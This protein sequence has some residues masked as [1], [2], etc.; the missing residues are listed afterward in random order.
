MIWKGGFFMR[1]SRVPMVFLALF[2]ALFMENLD[3]TVMATIAPSVAADLHGM[4]IF[5]WVFS[6]Y[7]LASTIFIPIFGKLAD[8]FGKKPFLLGGLAVFTVASFLSANAE[9][10]EQ[11]VAY[12]AM[13]GLG[14]APMM[15]IAFSMIYELSRPERR[16]AMQGLFGSVSGLSML[17]GPAIGAYL[18]D[19]FTWHWVFLMNIPLGLAAFLLILFFYGENRSRQR[20]A[21][22]YRGA[23]ALVAAVAPLM[24]GLALG[25]ETYPWLSAPIAGLFA[26]SAAFLFLFVLIERKAVE[27][28]VDFRLFNRR[29]AASSA[30]VFLQGVAAVSVMI[31]LPLY[32]Q[33][34]RGGSATQ[35]G[36]T[37][38]FLIVAVM[39]G[40]IAGGH[41]LAK[42]SPRSVLTAASAL[43][44]ISAWM[45]TLIDTQS[46]T[47][48]FVSALV[49]MGLGIGPLFPVTML[50]AQTSV[51]P[52][53][54]TS[55]TSLLNFLR[56]IGMAIGSSGLAVL[57]NR[58]VAESSERAAS[59]ALTPEQ[60]ELLRDPNV[61]IDTGMHTFVPAEALL[62]LRE[63]LNAGIAQVF[64]ATFAAVVLI[65]AFS[66]L[67]GKGK[68]EMK[69]ELKHVRYH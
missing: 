57:V 46:S 27:P 65:A 9:T 28:I 24:L 51:K 5:S 32:I 40:T 44:G 68:L 59:G 12:R 35:V 19:H 39:V 7:L 45:L 50:V 11:L 23:A 33:G 29:V 6:V 20:S 30:I 66:L 36:T 69:E 21:I 8:Q 2:I 58:R 4:H 26:A 25:G 47:Y 17:A 31:Y 16:G 53:A 63:G 64:A 42:V 18:T 49:V 38:T 14:A 15:P 55:I 37:M 62:T 13:Q 1:M 48:Y 3:H 54:T 10:M 43:L 52:D 61:L 60:T 56:N 22:D 34:V 41:L 67:S